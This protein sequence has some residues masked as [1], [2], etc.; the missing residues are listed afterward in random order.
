MLDALNLSQIAK[1]FSDEDAA[2]RFLEELRWPQGP[3][4]PRCQTVGHSYFLTPKEGTRT[5]RTGKT[6]YRR[7]WKCADCR[8]QFSV[9]VGTIFE[10]SK[11]PLSKWLLALH[12]MSSSKNGVA[13]LEVKRTLG[14]AYRSA[15]FMCDRIRYAMQVTAP[16]DEMRGVVEADETYVG[17][18]RRGPAGRGALGKTPVVSLIQRGPK[19]GV[20]SQVVANVNA[21]TLGDVL[22]EQTAE[23]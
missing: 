23:S 2:W 12:M 7:L 1:L 14:L 3:I 19:G 9:L 21:E 15:W 16:Q 5:T 8:E 11:I 18:R 22:R 13:A 10:A 17:G 4:C 20:R 6:S